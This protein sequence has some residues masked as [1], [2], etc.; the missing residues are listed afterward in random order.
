VGDCSNRHHA[1]NTRL[2]VRPQP[3]SEFAIGPG[4]L[5]WTVAGDQFSFV[6]EDAPSR[7][8]RRAEQPRRKTQSL[9][10]EIGLAN[11]LD[12]EETLTIRFCCCANAPKEPS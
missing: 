1:G 5:Q 2:A 12:I 10:R 9:Q 8:T 3:T 4:A 11:G 6:E 7:I